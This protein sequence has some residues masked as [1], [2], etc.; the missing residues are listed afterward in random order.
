MRICDPS[1][2]CGHD[3]Y[4]SKS[5]L[6]RSSL[7]LGW[8]VP[9]LKENIA[10]DSLSFLSDSDSAM[11][12][13]LKRRTEALSATPGVCNP[14]HTPR[15]CYKIV[16]LREPPYDVGSSIREMRQVRNQEVRPENWGLKGR[17]EKPA[18]LCCRSSKAH[19]WNSRFTYLQD[20]LSKCLCTTCTLQ[21][22]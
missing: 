10:V 1:A 18:G 21:D 2:E 17:K 7:T 22:R 11:M 20:S 15:A 8:A 14:G 9:H 13:L 4:Y 16:N 5:N 3:K 19:L 12:K 6:D